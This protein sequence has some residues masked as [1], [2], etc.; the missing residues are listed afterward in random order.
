MST[1]LEKYGVV[2]RVVTTYHPQTNGQVEVFN[3]EIKKLLQK[4]VNPSRNYWSQLL[5][6]ALWAQRTA[7]RTQLG[8]SPYRIVF[9]KACHLPIEI[10]HRVYWAIKKC[11]MAYDQASKERKL[12]LQGL[13]D[14][15]LEAYGNSHIYKRKEKQFHDNR[16]LRKEFQVGQKALLYNSRLKLIFGKLRSRWDGPFVVTNTFPMVQSNYEMRLQ[17]DFHANKKVTSLCR[18]NMKNKALIS[19]VPTNLQSLNCPIESKSESSRPSQLKPKASR[20][21]KVILAN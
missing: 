14:L 16:I 21:D 3:R 20:P 2:H 15:C 19:I 9:G 13:E 6:D 10:E 12:Q 8:M 11:N 1:L 4:M 5:E 7:Y 17:Q 18:S